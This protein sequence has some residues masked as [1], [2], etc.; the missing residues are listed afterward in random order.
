MTEDDA[1]F[2]GVKVIGVDEHIS[3]HSSGAGKYVTVIIDL[4]EIHDG[5]GPAGRLNLG[6]LKAAFKTLLVN[7][8]R[9]DVPKA[10]AEFI[11]L[12]RT[13]TKRTDE[14]PVYFDRSVPATDPPRRSTVGLS[15]GTA[16]RSGSGI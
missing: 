1:R 13:L 11:S 10:L 16:A 3:R 4:T 6:P 15:T 2:D 12:G 8:N 14:V 5:T 9:N 7:S